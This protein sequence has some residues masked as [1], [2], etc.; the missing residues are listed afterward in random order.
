MGW[1]DWASVVGG[2]VGIT[3]D[4]AHK[5]RSTASDQA[6]DRNSTES[7][8]QQQY[9]G[10]RRVANTNYD[11]LKSEHTGGYDTPVVVGDKL[12]AFN[13]WQHSRI[14][15]ALN[16]AVSPTTASAINDA[17]TTWSKLADDTDTA[18]NEFI[19]NVDQSVQEKMKGKSAAAFIDSTH[20]FC[21]ELGKLTV[22][23]R[24]VSRG[25]AYHADYLGQAKDSVGPPPGSGGITD[26]V[27]EHL[28]FQG[29]FK[30]P[31][32]R[33]QEAEHEAQRV[34]SD[35][36][37]KNIVSQV[38]N[39]RP[40]LPTP[41]S[42]VNSGN[43]LS[44]NNLS[45]NGISS[46]GPGGTWNSGSAN[47][48]SGIGSGSGTD[49]GSGYSGSGTSGNS[50]SGTSG[51]GTNTAGYQNTSG[52]GSSLSGLSTTPSDY[53]GTGTGTGSGGY[54]G[55]GISGL[56]STGGGQGGSVTG[57]TTGTTTTGTTAAANAAKANGT[58]SMT[59][60]PHA[61]KGKS[62]EESTHQTK[63]YLVYDRGSE[64]LGTLPPALPPGGVIG[65]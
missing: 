25:L 55:G 4:M 27:V 16:D 6:N 32:Y 22:A 3:V 62:D 57:T 12:E 14:W 59:G 43:S 56:G 65:G 61:N 41:S 9:D 2:V 33:Q 24:L 54:G 48:G 7:K 46:S 40:I 49:S 26:K 11:Q 28:P 45:G 31:H 30:G 39:A 20:Q 58:N 34:M 19:K 50:W 38:D 35:V 42:T 52:L 10:Q 8:A 17:A 18:R 60:M 5:S 29:M 63:D 64:L 44:G 23:Q 13:T 1:Q 21:T 51:N 15:N 37:Q 36:Y 53:S 47:S